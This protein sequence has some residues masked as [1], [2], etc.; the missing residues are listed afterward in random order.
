MGHFFVVDLDTLGELCAKY[1][2]Y[3]LQDMILSIQHPDYTGFCLVLLGSC[4]SMSRDFPHIE[5]IIYFSDGSAAQ[6]K[7]FKNFNKLDLS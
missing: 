3:K 6:Y 4:Y 7:N 5:K 2:L 1:Q